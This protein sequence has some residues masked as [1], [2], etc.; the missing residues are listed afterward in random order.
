LSTGTKAF[1]E[2]PPNNE[3]AEVFLKTFVPK[4][5]VVKPIKPAEIPTA[6]NC[7][8]ESKFPVESVA[9]IGLPPT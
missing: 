5:T 7:P 4:F 8:I 6:V 2:T 3:L 1:E 9:R